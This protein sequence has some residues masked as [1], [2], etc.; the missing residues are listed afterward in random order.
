MKKTAVFLILSVLLILLIS[1]RF[2]NSKKDP[3]DPS[4]P[5]SITVWHYYN[6][7]VK[8]KF[9]ALVN[10]FN[11]TLGKEKGIVVDAKSHGDVQQLAE[12]VFNA[13]NKAIGSQA[14]PDIFAAYPD[15]AFRVDQIT[16]LCDVEKYFT[17]EE[18]KNYRK[19]FV[20]EGRFGN[21]QKLKIIPIAKS[22]ENLYLNKT[23]WEPFAKAT[24]ASLED[25][26]TWE[27]I[28]K[29]AKKYKEYSGKAFLSIDANANYMLVSSIE[30][31][32]EMYSYNGDT[33][34][35]NFNEGVAS[36]I[37]DNYY[38]P[39]L[40]GY[41]KKTGRFSSDD[42]K[43]GT[44]LAYTGS[45]A[46]A[47]YFPKE[48]SFSST[49]VY[50][51]DVITLPYPHFQNAAPYAIQQGAGMCISKSDPAH[52]YASALFL[53]WFTDVDQ[54]I[55]FAVSTGYFPVKNEALKAD[56]ILDALNKAKIVNNAVKKSIETT[57]IMFNTYS[58]YGNKPFKG[59]YEMRTLL[60]NNLSKFMQK[61]TTILESRVRNGEKGEEVITD[62]TSKDSFHK[63]YNE[64]LEEADLTI[65]K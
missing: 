59:S 42:A 65:S 22:T 27:G 19:E 55:D 11:E 49:E 51:I 45:T 7:N 12:Q 29:T 15:N 1:N 20:D 61:N 43:T 44:V 33:A 40:N 24:G 28:I 25:L 47:A 41:F 39:S 48:V 21:E 17:S 53:K 16:E 52:E 54:N 37:W 9:D 30:L 13:A 58:L 5:V 38:V 4:K 36:K 14:M 46:G 57:V 60:E 23:Y 32:Q 34:K 31:G 62:L 56:K 10:K 3:L 18:L 26:S 64:F 6:G 35:L 50:P 8:D 2:L 63:W